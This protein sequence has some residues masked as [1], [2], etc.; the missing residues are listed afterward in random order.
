MTSLEQTLRQYALNPLVKTEIELFEGRKPEV[1]PCASPATDS[2]TGFFDVKN[3][4]CASQVVKSDAAS[5]EAG[6]RQASHFDI[7]CIYCK[8]PIDSRE[9]HTTMN[10]PACTNCVEAAAVR[11]TAESS[12]SPAI[13]SVAH[14]PAVIG[15]MI[16]ADTD[17]MSRKSQTSLSSTVGK[18]NISN[19]A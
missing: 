18:L 6:S 9:V 15:K 4:V 11:S 5:V 14:T 12:P 1:S 7:T 19:P 16:F 8:E 10:G 3:C 2:D 13:N 17:N